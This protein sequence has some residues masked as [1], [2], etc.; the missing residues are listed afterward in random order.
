VYAI[1]TLKIYTIV[2]TEEGKLHIIQHLKVA[3][4]YGWRPRLAWIGKLP[5]ILHHGSLVATCH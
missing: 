4:F 3:S 2:V 5:N 1:V